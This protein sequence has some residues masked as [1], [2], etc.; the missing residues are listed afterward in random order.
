MKYSKLLLASLCLGAATSYAAD[1]RLYMQASNLITEVPGFDTTTGVSVATGLLFS[2]KHA[3][4]IEASRFSVDDNYASYDSYFG[5]IYGSAMELEFKPVVLSYRY[6]FPITAKLY[7]TIGGALG[8]TFQE[9]TQTWNFSAPVIGIQQRYNSKDEALTLGYSA[10]LGYRVSDKA[11]V[12][13]SA[14]TLRM[15]ESDVYPDDTLT[16]VQLGLNWRF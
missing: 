9:V 13:L 15:S 3:V 7:G 1:A 14:R 8:V 2:G 4:E 16:L 10:G 5:G 6:E 12:V 11:A